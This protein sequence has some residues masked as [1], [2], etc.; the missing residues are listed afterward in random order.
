VFE[1]DSMVLNWIRTPAD[2]VRFPLRTAVLFWRL[3]T[4]TPCGSSIENQPEC[5]LQS[6]V[7]VDGRWKFSTRAGRTWRAAFFAVALSCSP[8][9]AREEPVNA[10]DVVILRGTLH[11]LARPE[12]DIGPS[13][14]HLP[15]NKMTLALKP[16]AGASEEL[17][18]LLAAQQDPA[19]PHYH[20]WL[21]PDEFGA[22]FG[23]APED[24]ASAV[25]WLTRQGFH[26]DS[27]ARSRAWI[28]FSG[29]AAQVSQAFRT[30]IHDYL[31]DEKVHHANATEIAIPRALER[32]TRGVVSLND[33]LSRVAPRRSGSVPQTGLT[34]Q[35]TVPDG[36][37]L[38]TPADLWT[39]YNVS[40]L[41][42]AGTAGQGVTIAVVGRTDIYLSDARQFRQTFGLP[43]HDPIVVHN[44]PAPGN[45]GGDEELEGDIDVEWA[46]ATAPQATVQFVVSASTAAGDGV[47]LSAEHVID[48]NS[49]DILSDSFLLCEEQAGPAYTQ[50]LGSLWAQAAAQGIAVVVASGDSG[51]A[52]CDNR[53]NAAASQGRGVNA[54]CATP[55]NVCVGG[56]QFLD[57]NTS[58]AYWSSSNTAGTMASAL[59]YI[60]E[61]AWNESGKGTL[62]A[63]GGGPSLAWSKPAWQAAPGVPA[64]AAR[65]TPDVALTAAAHDG[66]MTYTHNG[67]MMAVLGTSAATPSFGGMLALVQQASGSRLGNANPVLY[68]L[69]AAQYQNSGVAVFHDITSGDNSVPGTDGYFSG[70]G[71]D[72]ATGLGSLDAAAL[73]NAWP[74]PLA[75]SFQYSPPQPLA[76]EPVHFVDQTPGSP[77]AWVWNFGDPASGSLNTS[78][79]QNPTHA[80][81]SPGTFTVTLSTDVA[82]AS[83]TPAAIPITVAAPPAGCDHCPVVVPFHSPR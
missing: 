13:D 24:V 33:F 28:H 17:E 12:A 48:Q 77:T 16:R 65:D 69:G 22:R 68:Q 21:T 49:A 83:A 79:E 18:K 6:H 55:Y 1:I 19:S 53:L 63:S 82:G 2:R 39:I 73:V 31:V 76:T 23:A 43:A 9:I 46:G 35:L 51:A 78:S 67:G 30:E 66:Y 27:V 47:I 44:G 32:F 59:G 41:L 11:P 60:P 50:F 58:G 45:L 4:G 40:P 5:A 8:L 26:V 3:T 15:L 7:G 81:S 29:T 52:G 38:L 34:P 75:A 54:Q 42:N 20:R 10:S 74:K 70:P 62:N 72:L 56:T 64:D 25:D 80:F 71:Y 37:H 36:S 57:T 14:P 61:G